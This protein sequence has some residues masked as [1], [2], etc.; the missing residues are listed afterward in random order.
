MLKPNE[1]IY[2]E[3]VLCHTAEDSY[4]HGESLNQSRS[5]TDRDL[6]MDRTVGYATVGEALAAVCKSNCFDYKKENWE[7]FGVECGEPDEYSRFETD[8]L[9]C[10]DGTEASPSE[11][12]AWKR[13]KKRLWNCHVSAY[14]EVRTEPRALTED[15]AKSWS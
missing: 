11:I 10:D 3:C 15:E 1:K 8:T 13:G 4:E 5:W 9:V 14:L 7:N 2:I 12:E 6:Q